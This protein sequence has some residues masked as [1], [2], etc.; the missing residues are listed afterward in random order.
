[1]KIVGFKCLKT[2]ILFFK[3]E[4]C[5]MNDKFIIRASL[6]THREAQ[7]WFLQFPYE[8]AIINKLK[9]FSGTRW[10]YSHRCWYGP[11]TAEWLHK[12][13]QTLTDCII[14]SNPEEEAAWR[15]AEE[16]KREAAQ[17]E[18]E[19]LK[20]VE[21]EVAKFIFQMETERNA[22]STVKTYAQGLR[23][24]LNHTYP[25]PIHELDNMDVNR[26]LHTYACKN[27]KSGAWHRTLVS[28]LRFYFR[29]MQGK[30]IDPEK[31][32][33]PKK[34]KLLPH[35]MDQQDI[36][37]MLKLTTN[38]KHRCMLSLI[39]ACGLR[40]GD[41]L[42]LKPGDIDGK[43]KLLFIHGGKGRKD[44]VVGI[45]QKMI[46]TLR[47]YYLEYKPKVWLFEGQKA[48]EQYSERSIQQVLKQALKR[49]GLKQQASLH[50]LRHSFATH[51]LENGVDIAYIKELLGHNS[52]RTT[53]IYTHV[54]RDKIRQ[55][56][57]PFEDLD[58]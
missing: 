48:G 7:V 22:K 49:A 16:K 15:E 46:E 41:L 31:I 54:S 32:Y 45:P 53:E 56:R 36:Q 33:Y 52:I 9:A 11:G 30:L 38:K 4:I 34:E 58:L 5:S 51:T 27:P 2:A 39:Y 43:R 13:R 35:V 6:A 18:A 42:N 25:K 28:A 10:S 37:K 26:F 17:A 29:R 3:Q 47:E 21:E 12:L 24:F 57:S 40:R 50:W 23:L 8:S 55:I 14:I 19:K 1:M 20:L 44:R